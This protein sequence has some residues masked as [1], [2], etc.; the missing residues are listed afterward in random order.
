MGLG[1]FIMRQS[2]SFTERSNLEFEHGS[3]G[4]ENNV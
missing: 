4:I 1:V 2:A 3:L